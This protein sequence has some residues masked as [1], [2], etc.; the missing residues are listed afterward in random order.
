MYNFMK[1]KSV[2]T[3]S[4]IAQLRILI[5]KLRNASKKEQKYIRSR[6]RSIGLYVR[7]DWGITNF[8]LEDFDR[9]LRDGRIRVAQTAE[10][11]DVEE[12]YDPEM[13]VDVK[14]KGCEGSRC[15]VDIDFKTIEGLQHAGFTGFVSAAEL[16]RDLSIIPNVRGVYMVVRYANAAPVFLAVGSGGRHKD[17]D[18]NVSLDIL[19]DNWV[20]DTCVLY[21]G[22][23]GGADNASTLRKRLSQYLNFGK[24]HAAGH[25]G[26]RFI[27]QLKDSADLLFCW[28]PLPEDSPLQVEVSLISE[29]KR[30]YED[31]LPFANLVG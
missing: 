16:W 22:K 18:P 26:G 15:D 1:G 29:F 31:R 21:I 9:L 14:N 23:A 30:Q 19:Y 27:W 13:A 5:A 8:C 20:D 7:D 24:G 2:F 6:M 10:S 17:N 25:W 12:K 28:K 4:E 11:C 3:E